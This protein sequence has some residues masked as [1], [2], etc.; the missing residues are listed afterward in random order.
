MALF[1]LAKTNHTLRSFLTFADSES[2][3]REVRI[4]YGAPAPAPDMSEARWC[5]FLWGEYRCGVN[6][7]RLEWEVRR[8]T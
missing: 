6:W 1:V 8:L 3:W 4:S 5:R 7:W 2:V